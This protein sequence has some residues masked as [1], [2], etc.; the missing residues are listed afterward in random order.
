MENIQLKQQLDVLEK[1]KTEVVEPE[2]DI[3]I[4]LIEKDS[5]IHRLREGIQNL[6]FTQGSK[7]LN[8]NSPEVVIPRRIEVEDNP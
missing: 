7:E 3:Q 5:L 8:S 2:T 6:G 4:Q 1:D